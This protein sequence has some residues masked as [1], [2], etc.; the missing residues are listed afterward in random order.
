[1]APN[2]YTATRLM[3]ETV[4]KSIKHIQWNFRDREIVVLT[5]DPK[6]NFEGLRVVDY[7]AGETFDFDACDMDSTI[8]IYAFN[9]D[10]TG[11]PVAMEIIRRRGKFAP[12]RQVHPTAR[13]YHVDERIRS[14]FTAEFDHQQEAGFSKWNSD[15]D[16]IAQALILTRNLPGAYVEVGAFQGSS[17][18]AAL[19]AMQA[20]GIERPCFFLDVFDGF[21]YEA[22]KVSADASW[23]GTHKTDGMETVASRLKRFE[24]LGRP[25]H[26]VRNNIIED[27]LPPGT[28]QIAVANLDVDIYEGVRDGLAKLAPR[29]C[30]GGILIVEDP[31]HTPWLIGARIAL[32]E[33]LETPAGKNF[34]PLMMESGQTLLIRLS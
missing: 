12:I 15:F 10:S 11:K 27:D 5:D 24:T 28:E 13:I 9:F 1:M 18:C 33:W 8:F 22:A 20:V 26:V 14:A 32:D 7:S 19:A 25:V 30:V 4:E 3:P 2:P 34:M 17:G 16:N 23:A 6:Q 21:E 31:G 29:I